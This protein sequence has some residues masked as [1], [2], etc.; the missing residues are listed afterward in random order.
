MGAGTAH[1]GASQYVLVFPRGAIGSTLVAS[2]PLP[3]FATD[4]GNCT[5]RAAFAW[6]LT[7]SWEG[8]LEEVAVLTTEASC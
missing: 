5:E 1:P 7:A 2:S 3:S 6:G 8:F 4:L